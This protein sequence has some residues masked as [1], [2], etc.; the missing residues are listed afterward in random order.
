[1]ILLAERQIREFVDSGGE[2]PK[3]SPMREQGGLLLD[4]S[5]VI[6]R[7]DSFTIGATRIPLPHIK[8]THR[9]ESIGFGLSKADALM[10]LW[11][12]IE[13]WAKRS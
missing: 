7:E 3:S 11:P 4:D 12:Q 6:T 13:Q 5:V 9:N 8:L 1:M 2:A 10:T